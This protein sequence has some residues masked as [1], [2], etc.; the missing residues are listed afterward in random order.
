MGNASPP[1]AR[2]CGSAVIWSDSE[3]RIAMDQERTRRVARLFHAALERESEARQTF[4]DV[5]CAGDAELLRE[6]E[7]LL[8][9]E[10]E[11]GSFLETPAMG[12]STVT[13]TVTTTFLG[14]QFGPYRIIS[15]LGAGG[16]GEVYRA[17]DSKLGRDVAIKT[18][19]PEFARD[20]ERL[21]RLRREARM[22]AL[23]N[24]PNIAA[25]FETSQRQDHSAG[26]S[27]GAGFRAGEGGVGEGGR[28]KSLLRG[29]STGCR[30]DG[31][32]DCRHAGI[33]ES[34]TGERGPS[35]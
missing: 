11:A 12:Y 28:F 16:M 23:L 32:A 2:G 8:A 19:P 22:L 31:W 25:R 10:G 9:R 34:G 4:L 21:A 29:N 27:E 24:H 35:R 7:L 33:Y 6:V 5:E 1:F 14:Q 17:H 20:S 13:Q 15:A 30:D 26:Q 3:D 18:L